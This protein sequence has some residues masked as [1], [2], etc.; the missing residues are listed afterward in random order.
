MDQRD[1]VRE[2][3]DAIAETYV[4]ER[5]GEGREREIAAELAA[6]LP[7]G[8]RVLDAGCGAG[9]PA[10]ETLAAAHDVVGLDISREQLSLAGE[11]VPDA[12]LT[13][14][15]LATLPFAADSFDALVSYHAIIH[16]PKEEH[17]DVLS[18]FQRVLR[19]DGRLV[20]TMGTAEFED[21][22]DDWLDTGETMSWSFYG[23]EKNRKLVAEAGFE[24]ADVEEVDDELGGTFEFFRARA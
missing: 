4:Q 10:T 13:M 19:P 5:R 17:A 7:D 9:R 6:S 15:D 11:R 18:E 16:V 20:V 1:V 14:G 8:S 12:D 24:I 2:G 21:E 22:N 23:P 3:Y